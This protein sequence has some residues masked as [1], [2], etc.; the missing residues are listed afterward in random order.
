[1]GFVL[2]VNNLEL[3]GE[4]ETY[5]N[6][7]IGATNDELT[8]DSTD[9]FNDNDFIVIGPLGEDKT[10]LAKIVSVDDDNTMTI[11]PAL[12]FDQE[13]RTRI[14]FTPFNKIQLYK[15]DDTEDTGLEL[16]TTVEINYQNP[17]NVT[18]IEDSGDPNNKYYKVR[19]YNDVTTNI[20]EFSDWIEPETLRF[21][22]V[23]DVYDTCGLSK[24]EVPFNSVLLRLKEA[25]EHV[26]SLYR[27]DFGGVQNKKL[28]IGGD[29][30][31]TIFLPNR[32][33]P[34]TT[35]NEFKQNDNQGDTLYEFESSDY[36]ID[37]STGF[38]H[39]RKPLFFGQNQMGFAR[40]FANVYVDFDYGLTTI[41]QWVKDLVRL[42]ASFSVISYKITGSFQDIS[43]WADEGQS[44]TKG[45]PYVNLDQGRTRLLQDYNMILSRHQP[46][47]VE[48]EG[49]WIEV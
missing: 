25:E 11:T 42:H 14:K 30:D 15:A 49:D 34:V 28:L 12:K 19:F 36:Q 7:S 33:L 20:S 3:L 5:L 23:Q 9:K 47:Y 29:G 43:T 44:Y 26:K 13:E 22:N 48:D 41:P 24:Q 45:Q 4:E 31:R 32:F 46:L 27:T 35:I 21:V 1:M 17:T 37:K 2:R 40:G 16:V 6:A 10:E 39:L 18:F 8:V 38:I